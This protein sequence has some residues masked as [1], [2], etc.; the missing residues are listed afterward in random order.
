M[1][2]IG[3]LMKEHRLIER[4]IGLMERELGRLKEGEELDY[5]FI[6][7][8]VDFLRTYAD[9]CHHG[10]EEHILFRDLAQKPLSGDHAR[11]MRELIEEH[12]YGRETTATLMA[13]AQRH[14]QGDSQAL[15][16]VI[17]ALQDLIEFYPTHIKKEDKRFF[18][19][20]MSYLTRGEQDQM[21]EEFR[22]FDRG[23]IH[24]KYSDVVAQLA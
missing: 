5:D 20:S 8:A 21:L 24:E 9:R 6:G 1:M 3:P 16:T 15:G 17:G 14:V 10:K 19:P 11:I 13:A 18:V 4:M 23:L 12:V 22:E 7:T 2:P